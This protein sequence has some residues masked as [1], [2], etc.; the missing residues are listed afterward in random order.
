MTT[1][2]LSDEQWVKIRA[3]LHGDA[4]AYVGRDEN[5]C[6]RFVEAVL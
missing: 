2:K 3:F 5:E 4:N 6:R 1:V